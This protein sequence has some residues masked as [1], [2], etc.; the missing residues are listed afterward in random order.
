MTP[1][2][3]RLSPLRLARFGRPGCSQPAPVIGPLFASYDSALNRSTLALATAS[4]RYLDIAAEVRAA[5]GLLAS[6]RAQRITD[7]GLPLAKAISDASVGFLSEATRIGK[8]A[9]EA[10]PVA[11]YGDVTPYHV[12]QTDHALSQRFYGLSEVERSRLLSR[13]V[14]EPAGHSRWVQA[15]LRADPVLSGLTHSERE[16]I[17][18]NGLKAFNADLARTLAHEAKHVEHAQLALSYAAEV[19]RHNAPAMH[20]ELHTRSV[21]LQ[22]ALSFVA[23]PVPVDAND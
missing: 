4:T 20:S 15:L 6:E 18:W 1:S 5:P 16:S 14:S 2:D 11:P 9:R 10:T 13:V 19:L 22:E 7:A 3:P 17:R 21:A 23:E 8:A 12:V